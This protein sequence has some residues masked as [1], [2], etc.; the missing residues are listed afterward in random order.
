MLPRFTRTSAVADVFVPEAFSS[1]RA[2]PAL[3]R[4]RGPLYAFT[5]PGLYAVGVSGVALGTA[6]AMLDG[7]MALAC[8][9]APRGL[10]RRGHGPATGHP[11]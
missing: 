10:S 1:A 4:E 7:F 8:T 3:R 11:D 2:D 5:M 6:R 9:K